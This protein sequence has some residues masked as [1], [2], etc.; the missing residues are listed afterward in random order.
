VID[1]RKPERMTWA[2]AADAMH[3][4]HAC[5]LP[6]GSFEQHGPHLPL[7]TDTMIAAALADRLAER[8]SPDMRLLV[9]PPI[10]YG[11]SSE[12]MAFS[13]T[14]SLPA[15]GLRSILDSIFRSLAQHG[16]ETI[17]LVN[18]HGGNTATIESALRGW[19]QATGVLGLLLDIPR[20]RV[21]Q[22][23]GVPGDWHAGRVETSLFLA[24]TGHDVEPPSAIAP[25][26]PIDWHALASLRYPWRADEL[27][28]NGQIGDAAGA[29]RELGEHVAG[30]LIEDTLSSLASILDWRKSRP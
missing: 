29:S 7:A 5:L 23:A 20:S 12:H 1:A 3:G 18:G 17:L 14:A 25:S 13:G 6:C 4:A 8:A 19:R 9:L 28:T 10:P 26:S 11:V 27:S 16:V 22:E 30:R 2:E 15:D 21:V 24:L